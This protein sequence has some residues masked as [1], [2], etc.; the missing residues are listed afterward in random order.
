MINWSTWVKILLLR[1]Y[2][3]LQ[4]S[5]IMEM[6]KTYSVCRWDISIHYRE[7]APLVHSITAFGVTG[8]HSHQVHHWVAECQMGWVTEWKRIV[9][10]CGLIY[11]FNLAV[12][13]THQH[14]IIIWLFYGWLFFC[15]VKSNFFTHFGINTTKFYTI[16]W[17]VRAYMNHQ[18][19]LY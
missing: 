19:S 8:L 9:V 12:R 18:H 16:H 14:P 11:F 13:V 10:L 1:E 17:E 3:L 15:K 5:T 4:V 6:T 7:N 2:I